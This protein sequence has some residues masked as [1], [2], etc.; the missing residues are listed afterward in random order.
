MPSADPAWVVE[1][2]NVKQE[3]KEQKYA[4]GPLQNVKP[5][6]AIAVIEHI[7]LCLGRDHDA[8][9]RVE[10]KRHKNTEDLNKQQIRHVVNALDVL[11]KDL[12]AVHR[13][14]IGEYVHKEKQAQ[15]HNARKL[16]QF[17]Q[18]KG[19]GEF[20]RHPKKANSRWILLR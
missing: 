2:E 7:R 18:K 10:N 5:V 15:R 13:G 8:V 11:V 17:S 1:M 6:A 9:N 16:V 19:I 4:G 20:Y 3:K 14:R 12:R